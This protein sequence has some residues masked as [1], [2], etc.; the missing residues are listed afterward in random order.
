MIGIS[1]KDFVDKV[2]TKLQ[3][4]VHA[5]PFSRAVPFKF[6]I[7][8]SRF[9]FRLNVQLVALALSCCLGGNPSGFLVE[10][11]QQNSYDPSIVNLLS[12]IF[13]FGEMEGQID[14]RNIPIGSLNVILNGPLF[15]L[16]RENIRL[17]VSFAQVV[18]SNPPL[19][20]LSNVP[21]QTTHSDHLGHKANFCKGKP[22][23]SFCFAYGHLTK[24]CFRK[25]QL[26]LHGTWVVKKPSISSVGEQSPLGSHANRSHPSINKSP[27]AIASAEEP[28][29]AN[30]HPN[31]NRFLFPGQHINHGSAFRRPRADC[32]VTPPQR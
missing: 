16:K 18:L 14:V 19:Q 17:D 1:G 25:C 27:M 30:L 22:R 5:S 9:S 7:W 29:M 10:H 24:F 32:F 6:V 31:P 15:V 21:S 13:I 4:Q 28:P 8:F 26:N 12:F 3:S 11:L 20:K 2:W 23:C